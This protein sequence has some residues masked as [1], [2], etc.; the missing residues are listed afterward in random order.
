MFT[1]PWK[2][3]PDHPDIG[4]YRMN[5]DNS[6]AI[7]ACADTGND[8]SNAAVLLHEF[9]E[10][11]LCWI[12]GVTEQSIRE[13]DQKWFQEEAA[14]ITHPYDEPGNDPAAPY[15]EWHLVATRFEREFVLQNGMMWPQH[16]QNCDNV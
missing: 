6:P 5:A 11:F 1:L 15:H 2:Q 10:S 14:G 12:H 3:L 13:F 16:E 9:I 4:S 7:I 8:V